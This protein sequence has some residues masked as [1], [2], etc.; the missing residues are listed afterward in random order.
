MHNRKAP[1]TESCRI[2]L[3]ADIA[4]PEDSFRHAEIADAIAD[5]ML[6]AQGGCAIALT[7]SWGSGK[8]TVVELL[9]VKLQQSG[10]DIETFVF[11]T[12]AHQG[13]PLRRSFLEKLITWCSEKPK[14]WTKDRN[15]WDGVVNEI[16]RRKEEIETT[17][18]PHLTW[19]GTIG[20]F[21]LLLAPVALQLYQKIQ[22]KYHPFWDSAALV[23]SG[24]PVL[25]GL[26]MLIY[27]Y[28]IERKTAPEK[29]SPL[30]SLL[31]TSTGNKITSKSSKA[32]DLTS[33]EFEKY[34][35]DLLTEVLDGNQRQILLVVDNL[36][37][38]N[39]DDAR[40]M[41][42]ALRVFFDPSVSNSS[43]WYKRVWV[44]VPFDPEAINDL[45]ATEGKDATNS[46]HFLEKTFQAT[47]RVPPIILS[48]WEK[49]L[50]NLLQYA[51]P[52]HHENEFHAIFRLYDQLKASD[53]EPPTP[54][55][56]KIFVNTL[57]ALHH[58]WRE[59]ISLTEQAAFVLLSDSLGEGLV[60][61]LRGASVRGASS[62]QLPPSAA[63]MVAATLGEGWQRRLA[64][65]HFNVDPKDAYQTLLAVPIQ[66]AVR[67]GDGKAL[68]ELEG[69][70]GFSEVLEQ[71]VEDV[72]GNTSGSDADRL[73]HTAKAFSELKGNWPGH[74]HCKAHLCRAA[75]SLTGWQPFTPDVVEGIDSLV[76]MLPN[77][78]DISPIIRSIMASKTQ[79]T[80]WCA[81]ILSILPTLVQHD[82]AAVTRDFSVPGTP[83]EYIAIVS[84][85]SNAE[86][87]DNLWKYLQP[88]LPKSLIVTSLISLASTGKWT[89][90]L[91]EVVQSLMQVSGD[92]NWDSLIS[93]VQPRVAGPHQ[94][95]PEDVQPVI[96]TLFSFLP[97]ADSA[98]ALLNNAVQADS[99]PQLLQFFIQ[100]GKIN[101][102]GVCVLPLLTSAF[103]TNQNLNAQFQGNTPPWRAQEGKRILSALIQNP[104][105]NP[106]LL[107]VVQAQC[108]TWASFPEWRELSQRM[109]DRKNIIA[110]MLAGHLH[111]DG[112]QIN[113]GELVRNIDYWSG[114]EGAEQLSDLLQ[115]RAKSGEL[116][117]MLIT[118]KFALPR[119][120]FYL[121]A[122]SE[123]GNERYRQYLA[124]SLAHLT[125]AEWVSAMSSESK[126]IQIAL[127][128]R[129]DGLRLGQAFYDALSSH[130]EQKLS[131]PAPGKLAAE[132]SGLLGLLCSADLTVTQQRLLNMSKGLNGRVVGLIH[133]YG[134]ALSGV[135]L[136]DGPEKSF[137]RIKQIIEGQDAVEVRW[138]AALLAEWRAH[139]KKIDPIR[140]DW[141]ERADK[142]LENN[143]SPEQRAALEDL[144][145][146]L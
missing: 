15:H 55:N 105:Q 98:R 10:K 53:S 28:T 19:W 58:Q 145:K 30:P 51:F 137:E 88:D 43:G 49:Y 44:L 63:N 56:L 143:P 50:V 130:M 70:P 114:V 14:G 90:D 141:K 17:S 29:R 80:E 64:A 4:V 83:E 106:P 67:A 79:S 3:I 99:L 37:R 52:S 48:H 20:A 116:A 72:C 74:T 96:E 69:N 129:A 132:W 73:A 27:W 117:E 142:S 146:V 115:V 34:Y 109:P 2:N 100:A 82:E 134:S 38:V 91:T 40:A 136:E 61:L 139:G 68:A 135:V 41:W 140:N 127:A 65:L 22:F 138:L 11:D 104:D 102:A 71:T 33:V 46:K 121:L 24:A 113:T 25:V 119:C 108:L 85:A 45:W 16:A 78:S 60:G 131:Q 47:F 1:E 144:L 57:G 36:D 86:I 32:P 12:W 77:A 125:Q 9:R 87:P 94:S 124:E 101:A 81:G 95:L 128:L 54:R 89:T 8:S 75:L 31:F 13:D 122:L 111:E 26:L 123:D 93:A 112:H 66:R 133:Y 35:R 126:L 21:S 7:G 62:P 120:G 18:T 59:R 84:E 92:W 23:V 6:H 107:Q 42:S 118:E 97:I 5:M 76:R 103:Q 39:H 110:K